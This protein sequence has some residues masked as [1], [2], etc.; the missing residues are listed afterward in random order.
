MLMPE[1]INKKLYNRIKARIKA[2]GGRWSARKSQQLVNAYKKAGGKY[3]G[4]KSNSKLKSWQRKKWVAISQSGK[5]VG[6]CG[7]KRA[8]GGKV[9]R[10]LPRGKAQS[11]T[12]AERAATARK[13]MRSSKGIVSNTKKAR[14]RR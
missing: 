11:L 10:C 7:A 3:R 12:R 14:V 6:A 9:L 2:R 1:P 13:K 4:S 8:K 5:I